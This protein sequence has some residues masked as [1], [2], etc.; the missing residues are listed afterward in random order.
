MLGSPN[1][2]G[3][4]VRGNE[5]GVVKQADNFGRGHPVVFKVQW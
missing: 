1:S 3:F 4:F 2:W 5:L